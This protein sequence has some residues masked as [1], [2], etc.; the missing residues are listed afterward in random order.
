MNFKGEKMN[1]KRWVI[2]R[3]AGWCKDEC[4]IAFLENN[5]EEQSEKQNIIDNCLYPPISNNLKK[6]LEK[7]GKAIVQISCAVAESVEYE[8][9]RDVLSSLFYDEYK[10]SLEN[11]KERIKQL[12]DNV[13]VREDLIVLQDLI[14][15]ALGDTMPQNSKTISEAALFHRS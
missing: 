8:S 12:T 7:E 14:D 2:K 13:K 6:S 11:T 5:T 15:I 4:V 1:F 9:A 10:G 3:L